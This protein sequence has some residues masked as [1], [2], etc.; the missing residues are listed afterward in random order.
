MKHVQLSKARGELTEL[1]NEVAYQEHR[2]VFTRNGKD[3]AVLI[4]M[5]DL[6]KIKAWEDMQDIN[7]AKKIM[8]QIK[9]T[10]GKG[11]IEWDEMEKNLGWKDL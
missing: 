9:K 8:K 5:E 2:V 4:S 1:V 10:K 7:K 6:E 11:L 3:L